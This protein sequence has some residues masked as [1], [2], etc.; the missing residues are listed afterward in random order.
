MKP[1]Y[2]A[3]RLFFPAAMSLAGLALITSQSARA[4]SA[5]W[6]GTTDGNWSDT[7][8][9]S[10]GAAPFGA[11]FSATF[12]VAGSAG[13]TI[14]TT[15]DSSLAI[16]NLVKSTTTAGNWTIASASNVLTFDSG[17]SNSTI[18]NTNNGASMLLLDT[19]IAL[20]SNLSLSGS[21]NNS[22]QIMLGSTVGAHAIT[23]AKNIT[24][25]NSN[26]FGDGKITINDNIST[27]GAIFN[28]SSFGQ[29]HLIAGIIGI[30]VTGVTQSGAIG[31]TL[32][33]ANAYTSATSVTAGTLT[34]SGTS[35]SINGSTSVTVNGGILSLD[36][37]LGNVDRLKD[38]LTLTLGG[39][40][41]SGTLSFT[42]NG[43]TSSTTETIGGLSI[44]KGAATITLKGV[45]ATT[46]QTLA[47]G[48]TGFLRANNG[49][50]L[51]R[52]D[53]LQTASVNA[54][55]LLINGASG[56]GLT[57]VGG[58]TAAVG[59]FTAG[60]TKTLSIV[61][62][63]IGDTVN[64]GN[65]SGF[66]TYDTTAGTG[67]GL[68]PLAAG[69]YN[70]LVAGY[71]TA[72]TPENVKAFGGTISTAS[73]VTVN[74]LLF[75]TATQTL[76]GSGGKLIVNSGAVAATANTEMIG[77][78]FSRLT[79][80]NGT[81]NEGIITPTSG[82]TLSINTPIDVT[83]SG[84]LTKTGAGTL[85]LSASN[86]YTGQTTV[87]QGTL[88]IGSGTTGDLGSNTAGIVLNGGSLSFGR[89]NAGLTLAN[90]ISGIGGVTQSGA[91]TTV[92]SGTNSYTGAT[93][94]SAGTLSLTGSLA[95]TTITV[96]GTGALS[97][98]AAGGISGAVSLTHSSSGTSTLAG[99]NTYTGATTVSSGALVY[100][101]GGSLAASTGGIAVAFAGAS[102]P[103]SAVF[104]V[105]GGTINSFTGG[106]R[107]A[108]ATSSFLNSSGTFYLS[109][110]SVTSAGDTTM[111]WSNGGTS[112]T[113]AF[114]QTGGAYTQSGGDFYVSARVT[115]GTSAGTYS[116]SGGS[117]TSFNTKSF[118]LGNS[119][120]TDNAVLNVDGTG[121]LTV[122]SGFST[123]N[124]TTSAINLGGGT[125]TTPAWTSAGTANTTLNFHGG[126]LQA[127]AT[128]S[129]NFLGVGTTAV[130]LYA[131][132][133]TIDTNG[134]SFT[135]TQVFQNPASSGISTPTITT[136]DTTT[137]FT[138]P[139]TVTFTGGTGSGGAAYATLD[140]NGKIAGIIVTNVGSYTAAP[141]L[142]VTGSSTVF[143]T[144][145]LTAN[146][147]GGLT[148]I[149]SG[150]L[151]LSGANTYSGAT[152]L[153]LGTLSVGSIGNGG[154]ASGNLGS[155]SSAAGNLVFDGGTL[156]Y[157]GSTATSD[158]AFTINAGKTATLDVTNGL[159]LAGATG[160]ATTG[161]L[162]KIGAGT[163]TLNGANTYTGTTTVN[164]G[165]LTMGSAAS[166]STSSA[167]TVASGATLNLNSY[168]ALTTTTTWTNSGTISNLNGNGYTSQ[169]M[170][171]SVTLNNGTLSGSASSSG[172][173]TYYNGGTTTI[174]ANGNANT[175]SGGNIGMG[176]GL[177]LNTPL[178]TDALTISSVVG[179]TL[180]KGSSVT[181]SGLGTL[182][183]SGANIY[184]GLTTVTG[185]ALNIGSSGSLASTSTL[186]VGASGT[187]NFANANQTL[188]AVSN[189]NTA[190]D[191]LYFSASSG[192]VTLASLTGTGN[193]RFGSTG[194]VTSG[195][196]TGTV[197]SFA[198]LTTSIS[199]GTVGA[200]SLSSASVTGG[201]NTITGAAGITSINGGTTS[202]G[203][204]ATIGTMSSG[205]ATLNGATSVIGTYNGGTVNLGSSTAL[206]VSS[207]TSSGTINGSGSLTKD[208]SGT[209]ALTGTNTY[210][211]ITS[212]NGGTL[213]LQN[214]G[215]NA[216]VSNCSVGASAILQ[217]N[218]SN[219]IADAATLTLTG[220]TFNV[221]G[222]S[223]TLA[224]LGLSTGT[225]SSLDFG[226]GAG[227]STLLFSSL[228]GSGALTITNWNYLDDSLRFAS[229]P[230]AYLS[231]IT[232]NGGTATVNNNGT[233][234]SVVPEPSAAMLA[235]GMG[236]L[237]LLRRRRNA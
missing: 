155:A 134:N 170:P 50:M 30:N 78:G 201:T 194:T 17:A 7:T 67:G 183:L 149:S 198:A 27:S 89:T 234:F 13:V 167:I 161:A 11:G 12:T 8:K 54:T 87:N 159:S 196:S 56:T 147:T 217:L 57:L 151:T 113:G 44:D 40:N 71:T 92:L 117:M 203:G 166:L 36:N 222:F 22:A 199:G 127:N 101:T 178:V 158:R 21:G 95:G 111:S 105:T 211:G 157:T 188:G 176:S 190:A 129:A 131:G 81:W 15:L 173:G 43:A 153:T 146:S 195:I 96:S 125:L 45:G 191:A 236:G 122:P 189:S 123:T 18:Q 232:L 112:S 202:V 3:S 76:T 165:T 223:E 206:S 226:S 80:G 118:I 138:S 10:A 197:T 4:A 85:V 172:Y 227:A 14:T 210:T 41:G 35:G 28:T 88:Q 119:T 109:G 39:S 220:G 235:A 5:N 79:L 75:S 114:Y 58:G 156:Q 141:T 16:G 186:S 231:Q 19:E 55:R 34:V 107:V 47:V 106:L 233:Y 9:W 60:T 143:A 224:T 200:G 133:G 68:R 51:V 213:A 152:T 130:N 205:T 77:A 230:T 192:T 59:V 163:L 32:T 135:I 52:G 115:S 169:T 225:T 90:A 160:T 99:T 139:P 187:A 94:V 6:T 174:T 207:G 2:S 48:G 126:K 20:N 33:G 102:S 31:M 65:G 108:T 62:Y 93:A 120:T 124:T 132:G 69:E 83:G 104:A 209:L 70:T 218:A 204:V 49:T 66:L 229:D 61:P 214:S 175:I 73:D 24:F 46:L 84:A 145:S 1:K 144:P 140:A 137:V 100:A 63:F 237:A 110:G 72:A 184:T 164:V 185:G 98:S 37:S 86:L 212:V 193:T 181:K 103:S 29:S 128:G 221:N 179:A 121:A 64:T 82:N 42:G 219:Q 154:V 171:A 116:I 228:T 216:I 180:A 148:K 182:T 26:S 91:G 150:T 38:T 215:D 23:G 177:T 162:T 74:S 25:A 208:S 168:N 97:Q 53:S 142:S 136:S